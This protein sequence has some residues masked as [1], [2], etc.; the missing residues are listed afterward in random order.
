EFSQ[1]A[2]LVRVSKLRAAFLS[3]FRSISESS[4]FRA[5]ADSLLLLGSGLVKVADSAR[6][7]SPLLGALGA[8]KIG[9]SIGG[10]LIGAGTRAFQNNFLRRASG[11]PV[12][13]AGNSDSVASLLTPGEY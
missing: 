1:E 11:G 2:R 10:S 9:P 4:G 7:L 6:P 8:I 5:M 12:P 3:L 13:G